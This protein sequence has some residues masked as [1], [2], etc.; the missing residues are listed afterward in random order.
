MKSTEQK[1]QHSQASTWPTTNKVEQQFNE[2]AKRAIEAIETATAEGRRTYIKIN[3]LEPLT[4]ET[5]SSLKELAEKVRKASIKLEDQVARGQVSEQLAAHRARI[6][7][8][9]AEYIDARCEVYR[10]Q[11]GRRPA[12]EFY[13]LNPEHFFPIVDGIQPANVMPFPELGELQSGREYGRLRVIAQLGT[14]NGNAVWLCKCR[15]G[16]V[17]LALAQDIKAGKTQSCGCY[18]TERNSEAHRIHGGSGS[19]LYKAWG[20]MKERCDNPDHPNYGH[21]GGRGIRYCEEWKDFQNFESWALSHGYAEGLTLD[22][23][24]NDG[25][26]TPENC[27][28]ATMKQQNNNRRTNIRVTLDG[29]TMTLKQAAERSGIPYSTLKQRYHRNGEN[30]LFR[31]VT[32]KKGRHQGGREEEA[33]CQSRT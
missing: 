23:K 8:V 10:L 33:P 14:V 5:S 3:E 6:I 25:D 11:T 13:T 4:G 19:K 32:Y 16:S 22:R 28:W 2:L 30:G 15:C 1:R 12:G 18:H 26:Y 9:M 17:G 24:D 21:Y 7:R 29:E 31:P 27:R 20:S